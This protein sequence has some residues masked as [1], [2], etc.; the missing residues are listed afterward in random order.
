MRFMIIDTCEIIMNQITH[1]RLSI[2]LMAEKSRNH[3]ILYNN[4]NNSC[5][6]DKRNECMFDQYSSFRVQFGKK[7][8]RE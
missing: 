8:A 5:G 7:H 4:I 1:V 2:L 3:S 6:K